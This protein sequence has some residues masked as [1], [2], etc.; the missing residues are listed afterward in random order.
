MCIYFEFPQSLLADTV[1]LLVCFCFEQKKTGCRRVAT[2][3]SGNINEDTIA[4]I[5]ATNVD[6]ASV[7]AITYALFVLSPK[8]CFYSCILL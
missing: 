7:G 1:Y 3:A 4:V 2:E 5:A 8:I 6:F